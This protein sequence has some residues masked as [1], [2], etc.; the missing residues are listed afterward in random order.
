MGQ[1]GEHGGVEAGG[2]LER[3]A[4]GVGGCSGS[5]DA[6]PLSAGAVGSGSSEGVRE[7]GEGGGLAPSEQ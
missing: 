1:N 4:V 5:G 3:I 7:E 2:S 6:V